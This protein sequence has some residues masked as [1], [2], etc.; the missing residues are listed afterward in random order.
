MHNG[1]IKLYYAYGV[2]CLEQAALC[3]GGAV[4]RKVLAR[5]ARRG[6]ARGGGRLRGRRGAKARQEASSE[7]EDGDAFS[8]TDEDA[9]V[10]DSGPVLTQSRRMMTRTK[11]MTM[12]RMKN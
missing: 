3:G 7:D 11:M 1:A 2:Y 5:R 10:S 4:L 8:G 12:A 6:G 9:G